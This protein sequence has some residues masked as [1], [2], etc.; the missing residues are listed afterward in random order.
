MIILSN[1]LLKNCEH[2]R[3]TSWWKNENVFFFLILIVDKL[4]YFKLGQIT[5]G[6][7]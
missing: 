4:P 5:I 1:E 7:G 2:L 3:D 6:L